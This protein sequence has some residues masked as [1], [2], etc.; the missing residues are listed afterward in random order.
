MD[1]PANSHLVAG[2]LLTGSIGFIAFL[3]LGSRT[4][5]KNYPFGDSPCWT[6]ARRNRSWNSNPCSHFKENAT[7]S[8]LPGR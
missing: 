7:S 5:M 2:A 6:E 3:H 8:S 1:H 4:N